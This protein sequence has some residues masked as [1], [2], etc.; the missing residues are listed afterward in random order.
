MPK[1]IHVTAQDPHR[2]HACG[3]TSDGPQLHSQASDR[4]ACCQIYLLKLV[5]LCYFG[6]EYKEKNYNLCKGWC[7][8]RGCLSCVKF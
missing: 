2:G 1:V 8:A 6:A 3:A 4:A 7:L 5:A